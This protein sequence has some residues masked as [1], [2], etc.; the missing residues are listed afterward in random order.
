MSVQELSQQLGFIKQVMKEVMVEGQDYGKIPGTGEKPSLLQPGAQKLL[1]TF[2]LQ[3]EVQSEKVVD[4]PNYHREVRYIVR[5]TSQSGMHWDGVGTCSTLESKYRYRKGE[6]LCPRCGVAAIAAKKKFKPT[7]T[8]GWFCWKKKNGCGAE[9]E[10][11]DPAITRQSVDKVEYENPPDYW[12]TVGKMAFKRALVHASIN[13]TNTSELW[14]QDLEDMRG[15]EEMAS[16]GA[17]G[18]QTSRQPAPS[19]TQ[20]P[21]QNASQ[22]PQSA[23]KPAQSAPS[24]AKPKIGTEAT[25][26]W[27]LNELQANPGQPG[28]QIVTEFFQKLG[29]IL[30]TEGLDAV[31]LHFLPISR[32]ELKLLR[33]KLALFEQGHPVEKPYEPHYPPGAP[34]GSV[35]AAFEQARAA[36][37]SAPTA[38]EALAAKLEAAR[39]DKEWFLNVVVP[40]PNKGQKRDDY[41]KNP[42]T[43]GRLHFALKEGNQ[44]SGRRLWGFVNHYEPK[45]WTKN[46]GEVVPPSEADLIFREALDDYAEAHEQ[47]KDPDG[48][49]EPPKTGEP[50][51]ELNLPEENDIPF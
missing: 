15:N 27:M 30:P 48:N 7:D 47:G 22:T 41:L 17:K 18:P 32:A 37:A 21:R 3:E 12:N 31:P 29:Q 19:Q 13:A 6:R 45:P 33:D 50:S 28:C 38:K 46:N 1:M 34:G 39:K 4:L 5:V 26:A 10:L 9:F 49:T 24:P 8:E 2:R 36:A 42:D 11:E 43:I 25:R 14:T 51:P 44:E 16:E 35:T 23:P 40:I 20:A